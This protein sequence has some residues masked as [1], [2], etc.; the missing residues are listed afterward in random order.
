M[1]VFRAQQRI[2]GRKSN[3]IA[4]KKTLRKG[5]KIVVIKPFR[6]TIYNT[7]ACPGDVVDSLANRRIGQFIACPILNPLLP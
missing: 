7:M 2:S 5:R 3:Q 4:K 1:K 6:Q